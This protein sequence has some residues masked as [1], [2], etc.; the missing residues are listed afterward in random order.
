[1]IDV[2]FVD[3]HLSEIQPVAASIQLRTGFKTRCSDSLGE[4]LEVVRREH[5][6]VVVLD[7]R[8]EEVESLKTTGTDLYRQIHAIDKRVRCIIYSGESDKADLVEVNDLGLKYLDRGTSAEDLA[9]E[10]AAQRANYLAEAEHDY[11]KNAVP[12]AVYPKRRLLK[13]ASKQVIELLGIEDISANPEA[14][15]DDYLIVSEVSSGQEYRKINRIVVR[16]E[17]LTERE[18]LTEVEARLG[19][20]GSAAEVESRLKDSIRQRTESR[21]ATENEHASEETITLADADLRAGVI[22][23]RIEEAPLY[24]RQRALLRVRCEC[25]GDRKV[26]SVNL[27]HWVGR[28]HRRQIDLYRDE[29]RKEY[30]LGER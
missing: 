15:D 26:V 24:L 29:T 5:I 3:D 30:D 1:M 10:I 7:Q 12:I 18:N 17:I 28:Y 8:M 11:D 6:K 23:R 14:D 19:I 27:R 13:H 22:H 9:H 4:V 20:K 25:C 16:D 2:L 21:T